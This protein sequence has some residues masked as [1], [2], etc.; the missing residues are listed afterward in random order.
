[1]RLTMAWGFPPEE[2]RE[3][4]RRRSR[5][6]SRASRPDDRSQPVIPGDLQ[7]IRLAWSTQRT[8]ISPSTAAR[9]RARRSLPRNEC[10]GMVLYGAAEWYRRNWVL[11]ARLRR[12]LTPGRVES[13]RFGCGR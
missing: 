8:L 7:S 11:A 6:Q 3:R 10:G 1:M 4:C 5:R 9:C 2:A 13:S 12:R